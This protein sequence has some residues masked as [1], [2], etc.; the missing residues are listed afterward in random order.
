MI[1]KTFLMNFIN[2]YANPQYRYNIIT[3]KKRKLEKLDKFKLQKETKYIC[4]K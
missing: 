3:H 1:F 4:V 2:N